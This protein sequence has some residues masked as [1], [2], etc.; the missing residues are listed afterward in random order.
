[1]DSLNLGEHTSAQYEHDL[2]A[3]QNRVL[4]MGGLVEG[5]VKD[6]IDAL[7]N[8]DGALGEKVATSDYKVNA[9]EVEIDEECNR[10]IALRQPAASDLRFVVTMIK[11]STDLERVGDEAEK[12][13]RFAVDLVTFARSADFFSELRH[14]GEHVCKMLHAALDAFARMDVEAAIKVAED[15]KNIN[16]EFESV[17]RQLITHMME[18]PRSIK[19][20]LQVMWCARALERIGDHASNICEYVIFMVK[21]KDIRHTSIETVKKELL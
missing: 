15:D 9:L 5:Q 1:M 8:C 19:S 4:N 20:V 18:D 2:D 3:I 7:I 17:M 11:T 13:G 16:K 12:I 6:A 10:I 21:G 14:L